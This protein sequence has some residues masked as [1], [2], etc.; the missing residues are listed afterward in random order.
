MIKYAIYVHGTTGAKREGAAGASRHSARS[1]ALARD[2]PR[3]WKDRAL[4]FRQD[5]QLSS[6]K[7]SARF[8]FEPHIAGITPRMRMQCGAWPVHGRAFGRTLA[9]WFVARAVALRTR[10]SLRLRIAPGDANS[11][12]RRTRRHRGR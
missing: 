3:E 9:G 10:R 5:R 8:Q 12:R 4:T 1:S 6:R 11:I 2:Q 7:R